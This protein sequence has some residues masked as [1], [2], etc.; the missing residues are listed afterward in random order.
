[1]LVSTDGWM[2]ACLVRR[3]DVRLDE[4]MFVRLVGC[5]DW[6]FARTDGWIDS[7]LIDTCWMGVCV[8]G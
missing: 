1:M 2:D 8:L 5:I 6:M 7:G 4:R 3:M